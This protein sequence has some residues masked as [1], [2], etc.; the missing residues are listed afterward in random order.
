MSCACK[1]ALIQ[2]ARKAG[3]GWARVCCRSHMSLCSGSGCIWCPTTVTMDYTKAWIVTMHLHSNLPCA[4]APGT[5]SASHIP[6]T[7]A[8][9]QPTIHFVGPPVV[10]L[11]CE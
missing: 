10:P 9:H 5:Q 2:H 11:L 4:A 7:A 6:H 3:E 8:R 1:T